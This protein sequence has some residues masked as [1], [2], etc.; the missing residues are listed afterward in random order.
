MTRYAPVT[1][2]NNFIDDSDPLQTF[3]E[4]TC[5]D[6]CTINVVAK[7]ISTISTAK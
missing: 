3:F 1:T 4:L 5:F 2:V 7:G 6:E